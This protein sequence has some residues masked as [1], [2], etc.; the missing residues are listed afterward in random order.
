MN[1]AG[2]VLYERD[3]AILQQ[4]VNTL[5]WDLAGMLKNGTYLIT[6][7]LSDQVISMPILIR[8]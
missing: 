4:G 5:K 3:D 6:V 2:V 7:Q 1:L 8:Q